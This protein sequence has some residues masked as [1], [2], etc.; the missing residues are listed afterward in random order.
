MGKGAK[1]AGPERLWHIHGKAYDLEPWR[2]SHPGG[3]HLLDITRGTDCTELFESYHAPSFKER[4]IRD[5]LAKYAVDDAEPKH[6]TYEWDATPVYDDLKVVVRTYRRAHGIKATDS[7][8]AVAW[9]LLWAVIHFTSLVCWVAGWGGL[10]NAAVLGLSIWFWS[11]SMVHDGTHFAL[12]YD[13]HLS[14]WLGWLGGFMFCLP[15]TW[16]K[17]HVTAHH[18]HTN[19]LHRD[20]DC[21]HYKKL[22]K[23]H[24]EDT[25]SGHYLTWLQPIAPIFTQWVPPL[26]ETMFELVSNNRFSGIKDPVVW[27]RGEKGFLIVQWLL[28]WGS[29]AAVGYHHSL[30][31]MATPFIVVSIVYYAFSQVSHVNAGSFKCPP[32]REWVVTQINTAQGD[33]AITSRFWSMFSVGLSNQALHHSFPSIH[34]CHYPALSHL[35]KPV[36]LKHGMQTSGWT[37]SYLDSLYAHVQHLRAINNPKAT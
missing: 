30:L 7:W 9:I 17:Q 8:S 35:I 16:L 28:L 20:P 36:F 15:S 24:P 22:M 21:H 6:T 27:A 1:A 3:H 10:E 37:N 13:S 25:D 14:E 32:S 31:H 5:T 19:T 2:K 12:T 34:P 33:Y 18:V 11:G 4:W 29:I 26:L 23:T